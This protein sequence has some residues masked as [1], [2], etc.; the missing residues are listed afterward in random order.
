MQMQFSSIWNHF[1]FYFSW[2]FAGAHIWQIKFFEL[3]KSSWRISWK[4]SDESLGKDE[5]Y[6]CKASPM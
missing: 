3:A 6:V 4:A 5:T 2:Y 1:H